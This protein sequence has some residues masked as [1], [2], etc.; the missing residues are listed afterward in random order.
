MPLHYLGNH[1]PPTNPRNCV[2]SLKHCVLLYQQTRKHVQIIIWLHLNHNSLLIRHLCNSVKCYPL[3]NRPRILFFLS[4]R[5]TTHQRTT[6]GACNPVSCC[7]AKLHFFDSYGPNSPEMNSDD[8]S[9]RFMESYS[10]TNMCCKS[11]ILKKSSSKWLDSY[12]PLSQHSKGA[13]SAFLC[14]PR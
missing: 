3:S 12:K 1:E 8:Y 4:F 14:F 2:F 7:N 11:E 13:I 10:I 6:H 5:N 9:T